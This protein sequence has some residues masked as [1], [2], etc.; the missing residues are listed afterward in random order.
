MPMDAKDVQKY[1]MDPKDFQKML[2]MERQAMMRVFEY[3]NGKRFVFE[4][5]E[6]QD[7]ERMRL[8][9]DS[10]NIKSEKDLE[11]LNWKRAEY[12]ADKIKQERENTTFLKT[13][14]HLLHKHDIE[15]EKIKQ[16]K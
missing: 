6:K 2:A 10:L 7:V 8:F 13:A 15:L 16:K 3:A 14:T 9:H 4:D 11:N 12:V 1:Q 5:D